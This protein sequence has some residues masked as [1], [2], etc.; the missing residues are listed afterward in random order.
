MKLSIVRESFQLAEKFTI[1]RGARTEAR[2]LTVR[3]SESGCEGVGEC[4][5][6][7]R[8]GETLDSVEEQMESIRHE[9]EQSPDPDDLLNLLPCGAARNAIDC[10]LWHLRARQADIAV[11]AL[12][13]I[14]QP[15]S[16]TTAYTLSL[17]EPQ[18]MHAKALDHARRP[19][20]KIKLGGEQG[21]QKDLERLRSVRTAAPDSTIIVDANEGW[22]KEDYLN[23]APE[24][25]DLGVAMVEQPFPAADDEILSTIE[26]Q[27][28]V[29]ADESCHGV[30]TLSQ[31]QG[32]YDMINIKL[33]KTGGLT[34]ALLLREQA[35]AQ[36]FSVMV[37]CMVATSLAMAPALLVAQQAELV[38]LDGPLLLAEDRDWPLRFDGSVVFPADKQLW[39]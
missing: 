23:L 8:Y 33:D 21:G 35:R 24:L 13:N 29:C 28:P 32:K 12:A 1:S 5:P 6:Y 16:V 4:F 17:A 27:L 19:L 39:G 31:L 14:P 26:R 22:R 11:W 2:V 38:D 9:L 15:E 18:V 36:G 37:G 7:A 10:A 34:E 3:L 20:L 30:Q 25:V